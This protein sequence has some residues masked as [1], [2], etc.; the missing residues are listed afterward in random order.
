MEVVDVT[1]IPVRMPIKPKEE[2]LGLAP[3]VSNHG[4]VTFRDRILVRLETENGVVGW[5]EMLAAMASA[6]ATKS[7]IENVIT[8]ELIG[9]PVDE[10]RSFIESFYHPYVKID[11]FLGVI[12]M[13]MWDAVGKERGSSVSTMFGGKVRNEIDVAYCIGILDPEE[14]REHVRRALTH[15]FTTLKTKAG[16]DWRDDVDRMIAMDDEANGQLDLR[17]DANQGW[18]FED[19]VRAGAQLEDAGVYLQYLEQPVRYEAFG[20]YK[21]LRERLRQP[22]AVN[23]DTYFA[24]HLHHLVSNDA[25]DVACVDI[26]PAGGMLQVKDQVSVA[27]DAGISLSHHNGFDLGIKQAAVLH[28]VATTP[29]INL[30]PDSVY[31]AWDDYVLKDPLTIENGSMPVPEGPGLGIEVDQQKVEQ[32]RLNS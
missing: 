14:S 30:P 7:V 25:I 24:H 1:V 10:I 9:H 31:Y 8:P 15:G 11:P 2:E 23:E 12:E 22:I 16:P 21:R 18:N 17:L 28:T 4:H 5:G 13:A 20:T 26:I 27:A 29:T 3:Y 19:A 6:E 32:Y